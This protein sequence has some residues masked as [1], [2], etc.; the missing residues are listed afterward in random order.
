MT[1]AHP[2]D[3]EIAA[4]GAGLLAEEEATRLHAHLAVC[5]RCAR[6]RDDLDRLSRELRE[7]PSPTLP[8]DV[9]ARLDAALAVEASGAVS[10][11]TTPP[12]RPRWP[13]L[14]LA[15]AAGLVVLGIGALVQPL[16]G[17]AEDS[18]ADTQ[19][20][21]SESAASGEGAGS[22]ERAAPPDDPLA[23]QVH[24]LLARS[25]ASVESFHADPKGE[26]S[27]AE[28]SAPSEHPVEPL[29]NC[30]RSA[31]DRA[32]N[33]LAAAREDYQGEAAYLVLFP[34]RA[35]PEL[36]DAYVIAADCASDA[37]AGAGDVL[38]QQSY[39]RRGTG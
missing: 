11:E 8:P 35:D 25:G 17:P 3:A 22:G 9:A 6:V 12:P 34:H 21:A 16:S 32:D 33:P 26:E 4:L 27:T 39:P 2:E 37:D 19:L 31:I 15:A 28:E 20:E 7:L 23:D 18:S 14:A 38:A 36:V 24:E 29:P 13:R 1:G 10:R 30:V 5:S